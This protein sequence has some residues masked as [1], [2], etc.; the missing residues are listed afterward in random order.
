[1]ASS[2]QD[3]E[4]RNTSQFFVWSDEERAEHYVKHRPPYE[5]TVIPWLLEY[6]HRKHPSSPASKI[7]LSIDVACGSGQLTSQLANSCERVIGVDF[8]PAM[9]RAAERHNHFPNIDYRLGFAQELSFVCPGEKADIVTVGQAISTLANDAFYAEVLECLKP[10]GVIGI[11][12]FMIRGIDIPGLEN[13]LVEFLETE[14]SNETFLKVVQ[15][16]KQAYNDVYFP[17]ENSEKRTTRVLVDINREGLKKL[18]TINP[19]VLEHG[20][21]EMERVFQKIPAEGT[22]NLIV[23]MFAVMAQV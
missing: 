20:G 18:F 9:L 3:L 13:I 5:E 22:F 1:M 16:L 19:L 21:R 10:K 4:F 17:F 12:G 11:F 7:P 6:Y 2:D 14:I 23:D 15:S 8:S